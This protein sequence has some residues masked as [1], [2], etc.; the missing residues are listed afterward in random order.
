[1]R[2]PHKGIPEF[3]KVLKGTVVGT[4]LLTH[5]KPISTFTVVIKTQYIRDDGIYSNDGFVLQKF[6]WRLFFAS[7]ASSIGCRFD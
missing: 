6:C 1:M 3:E 2:I 7:M 5:L 4:A